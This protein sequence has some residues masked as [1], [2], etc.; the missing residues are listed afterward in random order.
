[1]DNSLGKK[2]IQEKKFK[3]AL[4]FFLNELKKGNYSLENYFFLGVTYFELN[5]IE[6]SIKYY[7]LALKISPKSIEI[8]I[9]LASAYLVNGNFL[10]A[11]KQYLKVVK[12]NKFEPRG[13]YG[14]YSID[15]RYILKFSK[16][17]K[18]IKSNNIFLREYLLSKIAKQN[19]NYDLEIQHLN[20]FQEQCFG[21]R[22]DHNLQGLFYYNKI[23]S[24]HFNKISF[25]DTNY[26][27]ENKNSI[28]P[29]FIIGLPRSGSTLIESMIGNA[30]HKIKTLGETSIFNTETIRLIK[31]QIFKKNFNQENDF[32]RL[33][34]KNLKK[35]V[36]ER[37]QN[38]FAEDEKDLFIVDKSLEN[39][40]NI[41]IILK[42]FPNAK[43]IN[44]RRNLNDNAIAIYQAMLLDLP[45]THSISDILSYINSYVK[46]MS[47]YEKKKQSNI[48]SIDLEALTS[49]QETYS[50]RI[51]DF[52]NLS[53]TK[54]VLKFKNKSNLLIKT[55]SNNQVR[56]NIFSYNKDKYK[57]YNKLL[58]IYLDKYYWL[59]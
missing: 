10:S 13:Y 25:E 12:I 22:K 17:I 2:F 49:D 26:K 47:F 54:D 43:F 32:I 20:I 45:W 51:F 57:K 41:E 14:L 48:L 24:K 39:F 46:I 52:C 40:F 5:E 1:M 4:L 34:I 19:K 7:K 31:D 8:I 3:K 29:I 56:Q 16:D 23:I 27:N 33:N 6:E 18:N 50:K 42:I 36:I 53:W 35:N 37:Y 55:L 28:S 59:K 21:L 38:Y 11:E 30:R 58:D 44:C 9:N 15:E